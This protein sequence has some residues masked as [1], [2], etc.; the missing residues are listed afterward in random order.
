LL[1]NLSTGVDELREQLRKATPARAAQKLYADYLLTVQGDTDS[2]ANRERRREL[3]R[4]L[5]FSL[6]QRKDDKRGFTPE[7]RRILWNK[8]EKR[9]CSKCGKPLTWDK[10][11]VD[12]GLAYTKG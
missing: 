4:S 11:T 1:R 3:L 8:D 2:S 9:G 12:H 10:L 5:L 6:F 7:Q